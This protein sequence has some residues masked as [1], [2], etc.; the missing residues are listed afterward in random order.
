MNDE[1]IKQALEIVKA[2]A[3]VRSMTDEEIIQMVERI[4]TSIT[5]LQSAS[6]SSTE[7][8]EPYIAHYSSSASN[9]VKENAIVCLECGRSFRILTKRH[10]ALHNLTCLL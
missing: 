7:N 8:G 10:L 4:A 6:T 9:A 3:G 2:Q 5:S 1:S